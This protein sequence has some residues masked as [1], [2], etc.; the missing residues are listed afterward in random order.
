M[1]PHNAV[2]VVTVV[3]PPIGSSGEMAQALW[4]KH[5]WLEDVLLNCLIHASTD[6]VRQVESCKTKVG[7]FTSVVADH[8]AELPIDLRHKDRDRPSHG[9]GGAYPSFIQ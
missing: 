5:E 4:V 3:S 1:Q 7:A 6:V 9:K 8:V 2:F